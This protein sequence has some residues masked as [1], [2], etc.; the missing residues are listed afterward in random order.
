MT[1]TEQV[2]AIIVLILMT[3]TAGTALVEFGYWLKGRLKR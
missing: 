2:F 3:I 1:F